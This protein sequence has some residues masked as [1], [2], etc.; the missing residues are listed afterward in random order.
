[1]ALA[2]PLGLYVRASRR[3]R[4]WPMSRLAA[5][6]GGVAVLGLALASP[7]AVLS[8]GLFSVHMVQ[9]LALTMVAAPLLV[10]GAPAALA[11]RAAPGPV[12]R[13]LGRVLHSGAVRALGHPLLAWST[14]ALVMWVSHFS[15]LYDLALESPALHAAEHALYLGAGVLFWWPVAGLDPGAAHMTHPVRILYLVAA[16]PQQSFL[17]LAIYSASRV[18]YPHYATLETPAWA[19]SPAADQRIAGIVMWVGGDFLF[20]ACLMAAIAAWIRHERREEA[21]VDRRLGRIPG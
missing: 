18:L 12:R 17:G 10:L 5:F 14:F 1:M 13:R 4:G 6:C 20:I 21:R 3:V 7:V 11:L 2:V 8:H 15:S 19:P 16:L 9:H